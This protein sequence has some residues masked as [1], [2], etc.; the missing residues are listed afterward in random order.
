MCVLSGIRPAVSGWQFVSRLALESQISTSVKYCNP[1]ME[2]ERGK[3][4]TSMATCTAHRSPP[5]SAGEK[6][7]FIRKEIQTVLRQ[8]V[9]TFTLLLMLL[10]IAH[11]ETLLVKLYWVHET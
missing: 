11:A 9:N 5:K 2:M 10:T 3:A 6:L 4:A 1:E 7:L 8:Q